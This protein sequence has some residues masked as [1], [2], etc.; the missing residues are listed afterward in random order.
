[1]RLA[2][3]VLVA[4]PLAGCFLLVDLDPVPDVIDG[5]SDTSTDAP[6]ADA[7]AGSDVVVDASLDPNDCGPNHAVCTSGQCVNSDCVRRIFVLSGVQGG[8]L[9]TI[10]GANFGC[11]NHGGVDFGTASFVPVMSASDM[12]AR[13]RVGPS[14]A[15]FVLVDKITQVAPNAAALFSG[16]LDHIIDQSEDGGDPGGGTQN[17]WTGSTP[18]GGP[19]PINDCGDWTEAGVSTGAVGVYTAQNI[20]WLRN[21]TPT[22]NTVAHLYCVEK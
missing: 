3:V 8:D 13:D 12:S 10:S 11:S 9:G 1:L 6:L 20:G 22:C 14:N 21:A 5:G 15:P 7:D 17:V 19:D 18:D 16:S 2:L 4:A